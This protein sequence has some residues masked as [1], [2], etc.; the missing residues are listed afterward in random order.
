MADDL[1]CFTH[2]IHP[3]QYR[4]PLGGKQDFQRLGL[5]VL[6]TI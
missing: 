5:Y 6:L 2:V 1:C 3:P 4:F